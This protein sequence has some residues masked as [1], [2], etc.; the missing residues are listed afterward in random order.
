LETTAEQLDIR[1]IGTE[2]ARDLFQQAIASKVRP[3]PHPDAE[4]APFRGE[5]Q[6]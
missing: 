2:Q 5:K 4:A 1:T 6:A 3:Y